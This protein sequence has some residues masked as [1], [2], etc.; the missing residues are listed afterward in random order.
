MRMEARAEKALQNLED[1]RV[2]HRLNPMIPPLGLDDRTIA[3]LGSLLGDLPRLWRHPSVT[4]EQRKAIARTLFT[5]VHLSMTGDTWPLEVEWVGGART[6]LG[7]SPESRSRGRVQRGFP[8]DGRSRC[9]HISSSGMKSPEKRAAGNR[10]AP[11][12]DRLPH[13]PLLTNHAR[14]FER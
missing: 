10:S 5:R 7:L 11:R 12:S 14:E 8:A 6:A 4:P 3:E 9:L 13:A 2:F 1:L